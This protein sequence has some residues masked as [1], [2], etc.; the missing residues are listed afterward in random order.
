M[1]FETNFVIRPPNGISKRSSFATNASRMPSPYVGNPPDLLT[2]CISNSG[3]FM[4]KGRTWEN[5]MA[6]RVGETSKLGNRYRT[7]AAKGVRRRHGS[8]AI[9]SC[10]WTAIDLLN[11]KHALKGAGMLLDVRNHFV[12]F[13]SFPAGLLSRKL[14]D[15]TSGFGEPNGLGL[16][17]RVSS[18]TRHRRDVGLELLSGH[19]MIPFRLDHA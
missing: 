3:V 14:F 9:Q 4:R 1:F 2:H 11:R 5:V 19:A 15:P 6:A 17:H 16:R 18:E 10:G 8:F 7:T 13:R 12:T